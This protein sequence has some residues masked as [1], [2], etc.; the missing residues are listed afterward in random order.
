MSV[1]LLS[2][3]SVSV[4][5]AGR[6]VL[7]NVS[8]TVGEGE[9]FSLLGPSGCGK[10]TLLRI[11]A[12]FLEP[13]RGQ[14]LW[15]GEEIS[16]QPPQRRDL[17]L[18]F[19]NYA[20]FSHLSVFENVAFGLHMKKMDKASIKSRVEE[21]LSLV[22]M[23]EHAHR[24]VTE[25]S[26]GQQQRIALARAIAPRPKLVL[27]DEPLGALDLQLRKEMQWE[28]K[29]LQQ[30]LKM[31]FLYVTHDQEEA[32]AMS[33]RIAILSQGCLEQISTPE[34]LYLNPASRFV[35]EFIGTA[36]FLPAEKISPENA[37][38]LTSN[39][40]YEVL[41][42]VKESSGETYPFAGVVLLRPEQIQL[43]SPST[44]A[45]NLLR[46]TI[47]MKQYLGAISRY[48]VEV[49]QPEKTSLTLTVDLPSI[50]PNHFSA[51]E[52]VEIQIT[53]PKLNFF[54]SSHSK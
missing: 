18:V 24:K 9:F 45:K 37:R 7:N 21:T 27:L 26:G 16:Q 25:L 2:I 38:C 17:N 46:G 10:T 40:H 53:S 15:S 11:I 23:G 29:S 41:A 13:T 30:Q 14:I 36:N 49:R 54:P 42:S 28:L 48:H 3:N 19:Q 1:P 47:Q 52:D 31:T 50:S 44:E 51:G 35:A 6:N 33:D 43:V 4:S 12:G 32:F 22:R 8:M 39:T 20:L 34:E 5:M